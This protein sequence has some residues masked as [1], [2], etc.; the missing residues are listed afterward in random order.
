MSEPTSLTDRAGRE[1]LT[2]EKAFLQMLEPRRYWSGGDRAW[3]FTCGVCGASKLV[4]RGHHQGC[5]FADTKRL[6]QIASAAVITPRAR[7]LSHVW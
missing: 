7:V 1:D 4:D 2:P 3:P 5:Q 6:A